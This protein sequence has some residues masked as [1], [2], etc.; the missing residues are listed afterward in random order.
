M[1]ESDGCVESSASFTDEIPTIAIGVSS[2][3]IIAIATAVI[4]LRRRK[5]ELDAKEFIGHTIEEFEPLE[6][7]QDLEETPLIEENVSAPEPGH[8][9]ITN[10]GEKGDDGYYWLEWPADSG[11]W[12]YRGLPEDEWSIWDN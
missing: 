11:K 10:E 9:P 2:L 8:P 12:Y 6:S 4:L 5:D 7:H 1:V 3:G